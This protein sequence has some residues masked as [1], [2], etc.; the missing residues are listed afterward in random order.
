MLRDGG[1]GRYRLEGAVTLATVTGLRGAGLQ[2]F[3]HTPGPIE[4]DLSGVGRADSGALA[5]LVDWLA[6]A[7]T[8]HRVLKFSAPPAALLALARLSDV[9]DLLLGTAT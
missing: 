3:A 2:A 5:L 6:W 4:V 1:G 9:E 7:R 8:A